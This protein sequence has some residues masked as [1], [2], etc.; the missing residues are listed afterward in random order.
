MRSV[1][2]SGTPLPPCILRAMQYLK[3]Q[4]INQVGLFRKPGV[5]SRIQSLREMVEA[6]PDGVSFEDQ[7]AF[8]VADM[9]KQYFRDLPEPVFTEKLNESFLHIYQYFPK[10]QQFA[11]V[12]AA[13]FLLPDEN[14]EALH[15]LLLFL[16][17]VAA[18]RQENQMG[19]TNIAVCLA[20]SI[21]HLSTP[22]TGRHG[23]ARKHSLVKPDQRDLSESLAATQGLAHMLTEVPRLFQL[24]GY[25]LPEESLHLETSLGEDQQKQQY[26]DVCSR[27]LK[28][29]QSLMAETKEKAKGWTSCPSLHQH[30]DLAYKKMEDEHALRL[31]RGSVEVDCPQQEAL[32]RVLR[33]PEAWAGE[34]T[35]QEARVL[36]TLDKDKEVYSY[37]L[38][39]AASRPPLQHVLLRTWQLESS[40]GP[41][42]VASASVE[43]PDVAQQG[44][45]AQ[46]H[47]CLF[48]VEPVGV[49]RSRVTHFCR[50]DTRGRSSEWHNKVCG[51][52]LAAGL[53]RLRE[54]FKTKARDGRL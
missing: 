25:S 36:Q 28:S 39:G 5:K 11:A 14:R 21:F 10:D 37:T 33:E 38:Q 40:A 6:D 12:R 34:E 8:D 29:A 20:P 3:T 54:S 30:V 27:L 35:L 16:R 51:H 2:M 52:Q 23:G 15:S 48:L 9:V 13:I 7:S 44:I 19:I 26:E 4:C 24:P 17:E 45:R 31:W 50:T 18:A 49:K 32:Q 47:T 53:Q 42:Y 46:V 1:Q 43:H 22:R 41:L